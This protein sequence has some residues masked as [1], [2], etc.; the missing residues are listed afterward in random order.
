[1]FKNVEVCML[2]ARSESIKAPHFA[3][4]LIVKCVKGWKPTGELP[5]REGTLAW[6]IN[7]SE[8]VLKYYQPQHLYFLSDEEIK[9]GDWC[10]NTGGDISKSTPFRV[11]ETV[12]D[13][14]LIKKIIATTD[15]SLTVDDPRS[16][17]KGTLMLPKP[18]PSFIENFIEEYN[19][20]NVITEVLVEYNDDIWGNG[21]II[22]PSHVRVDSKDNTIT[23]R[24]VKDNWNREEVAK[25]IEKTIL[26]FIGSADDEHTNDKINKWIEQNL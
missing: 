2:P 4:D 25:L 15:T 7:N 14:P 1:M 20:G 18:S 10:V 17:L 19:N 9:E 13:F 23:T 12:L 21:Q 16:Q 3:K 26:N 5:I 22:I 8:G 11:D 24:K 6:C